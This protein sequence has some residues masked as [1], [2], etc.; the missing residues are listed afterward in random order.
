MRKLTI[1]VLAVLLAGVPV[2]GASA[3]K[4]RTVETAGDI[5]GGF[6]EPPTTEGAYVF[7]GI[8]DDER[9]GEGAAILKGR[10]EGTT[11]KGTFRLF[12]SRGILRGTFVLTVTANGDGTVGLQG[13][14]RATGG[15]GAF[16]GA[17]G[18]GTTSGTQDADG[19]AQ[20][21]YDLE[22]KLPPRK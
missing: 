13:T 6:A 17:K 21:Q 14:L 11:S 3:Q 8:V 9:Y 18:S 12:A 20:V 19:Y 10:F 7:A 2:A 1:I 15:S 5:R 16:K 22:L 4:R